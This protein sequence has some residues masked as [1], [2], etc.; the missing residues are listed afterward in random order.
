M[1]PAAMRNLGFTGTRNGLTDAQVATFTRLVGQCRPGHFFHG[2]CV[3]ADTDAARIVA[4][5]LKGEVTIT[6]NP[7][8]PAGGGPNEFLSRE[9]MDLSHY[10]EP[11][12]GHFQ[13]NRYIV[14]MCDALVACP[15]QDKRPAKGTGGGTWY[16]V[17][18][19]EK[20]GKRVAIIWPDGSE[21]FSEGRP[22]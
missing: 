18:Y 15:W 11:A 5:V 7:G 12:K 10:A 14:D 9:A 21:S 1:E 4:G 20:V 17:E 13:R 2:A 3:G 16:T 6:A 22:S 19:A 8:K